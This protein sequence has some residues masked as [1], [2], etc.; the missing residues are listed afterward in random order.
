MYNLGSFI[1][2]FIYAVYVLLHYKHEVY[3][4]G[5]YIHNGGSSRQKIDIEQVKTDLL[6]EIAEV[7]SSDVGQS[8]KTLQ[9]KRIASKIINR[10]YAGK[11]LDSEKRIS[12]T[13]YRSTLRDL[14]LTIK[15]AGYRHHSLLNKRADLYNVSDSTGSKKMPTLNYLIKTYPEFKELYE[16]L[17]NCE[18]VVLHNAKGR[19]L[20]AIKDSDSPNKYAAYNITKNLRVEHEV[21]LALKLESYE[22]DEFN[23]LSANALKTKQRNLVK[24]SYTAILNII[25]D[26]L[27]SDYYTRQALALA[28]ATGRRPYEL[29]YTARF[30]YIDDGNLMFYGQ[31]KKRAGADNPPYPIKTLIPSKDVLS[32]FAK[33]RAHESIK[34]IHNKLNALK[35]YDARYKEFNRIVG[36]SLNEMAKR[37]FNDD[38]D[39][40]FKDSR[41]IYTRIALDKLWAQDV[42]EEMFLASLLGHESDNEQR[43]Y[44]RFLVDYSDVSDTLPEPINKTDRYGKHKPL[45]AQSTTVPKIRKILESYTPIVESY[46]SENNTGRM[47]TIIERDIDGRDVAVKI[48]SLLNLHNRVIEFATLYPDKLITKTALSKTDG[49]S[50][51]R[52]LLEIYLN[53]ILPEQIA[54]YNRNITKDS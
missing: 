23:Q 43:H 53:K 20:K 35:H 11:R 54:E 37:L 34:N 25:N 12:L 49:F 24:Y 48:N 27:S 46:I 51:S 33:L 21:C 47:M 32:A 10:L 41:A 13:Y 7:E 52:P 5:Y 16:Q 8:R 4:M 2:L 36:S 6:A 39:R 1:Y 9:F 19:L 14:R 44:K 26:N 40:S 31:A 17:R 15:K 22:K 50:F 30:E 18:P 45:L 38:A 28:L 42:Q 3:I 29:L